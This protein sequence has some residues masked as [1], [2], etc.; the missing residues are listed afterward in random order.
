MIVLLYKVSPLWVIPGATGVGFTVTVDTAVP[1]QLP[2]VPVT[3]YVVVVVNTGVVGVAVEA[4][5]PVHV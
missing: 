2:L 1:V 3:V 5:P 4:K